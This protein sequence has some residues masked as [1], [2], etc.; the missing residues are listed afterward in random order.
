MK[1]N[2]LI[3]IFILIGLVIPFILFAQDN[4]NSF[5]EKKASNCQEYLENPC[6]YDNSSENWTGIMQPEGMFC[7]R[8]ENWGRESDFIGLVFIIIIAIFGNLIVFIVGYFNYK[9]EK[10]K[11]L[12]F[13]KPDWKKIIL[14]N[15]FLIIFSIFI[16]TYL[17][18]GELMY[19]TIGFPLPFK[20]SE[21]SIR[22]GY[23][24]LALIFSLMSFII[25]IVF[26]YFI[27]HL[28]I[29]IYHKLKRKSH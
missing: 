19:R 24:F 23:F 6:R 11:F 13:L 15:I 27:C 7:L 4:Q 18:F 9:K 29:S 25:D 2:K 28:L 16:P 8:G 1:K 14:S 20:L 12:K 17:F 5:C 22:E 26:W 3:L 10:I 21:S